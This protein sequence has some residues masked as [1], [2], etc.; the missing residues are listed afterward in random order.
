MFSHR[1]IFA[2]LG[3][4]W[5]VAPLAAAAAAANGVKAGQLNVERPT[6]ISEGFDWRIDGD[7]NRNATVTVKYRK[8]GGSVWKEGLPFLRAGGNGETVGIATGNGDAAAA[9]RAGPDVPRYAEF[10]YLVPNMLAGS[11]FHLQADT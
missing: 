11:L 9:G 8:K 2:A 7:D 10:K 5:T 6:L 1:L 4:A 3:L